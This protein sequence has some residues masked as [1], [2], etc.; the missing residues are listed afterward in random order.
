M[1]TLRP[2]LRSAR[3]GTQA[4]AI[5]MLVAVGEQDSRVEE[6]ALRWI[7]GLA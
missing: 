6:L 2:A 3:C 5:E 1:A 7:G 4:G